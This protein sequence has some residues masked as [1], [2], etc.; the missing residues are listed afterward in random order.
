MENSESFYNDL[1]AAALAGAPLEFRPRVGFFARGVSTQKLDQLERRSKTG[2]DKND[3]PNRYQVALQVHSLTGKMKPVLE[4]LVARNEAVRKIDQVQR[5]SFLYFILVLSAATFGLTI[6]YVYVLPEFSLLTAD[7]KIASYGVRS[8][9]IDLLPYFQAGVVGLLVFMVLTLV[10]I[11]LGGARWLGMLLGGRQ[12]LN[13]CLLAQS[14]RICQAMV[15]T[16]VDGETASQHAC[17]LVGLPSDQFDNVQSIDG[18]EYQ[19][20]MAAHYFSETAAVQLEGLRKKLPLI[21]VFSVGGIVTL[22]YSIGLYLPI[23]SLFYDIVGVG[24]GTGT[25][26]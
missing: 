5:W 14:C 1:K 16:G 6:F 12:F 7:L 18:D 13:H 9:Q 24:L 8:N 4:G 21:L 10:F 19:L 2:N 11:V 15:L 25:N 26:G 20:T 17:Q 22:V 3:L 23:I